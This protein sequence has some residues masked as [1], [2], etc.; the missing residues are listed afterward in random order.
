MTNFHII[1]GLKLK[2]SIISKSGTPEAE[3]AMPG[4][5]K[6]IA[7]TYYLQNI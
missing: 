3:I 1:G 7:E 2:K 4:K 5:T 6:M